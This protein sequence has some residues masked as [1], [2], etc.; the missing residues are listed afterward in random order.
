MRLLSR[1]FIPANTMQSLCYKIT[2]C[3]T[4][5]Y[6]VPTNLLVKDLF[7]YLKVSDIYLSFCT[8]L[9]FFI[10][11]HYGKKNRFGVTTIKN[12]CFNQKVLSQKFLYLFMVSFKME[13]L[14]KIKS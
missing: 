5:G 14:K 8:F 4:Q 10:T 2:F 12:Y 1:C 6:F 13:S 3:N 9:T 7:L 11:L